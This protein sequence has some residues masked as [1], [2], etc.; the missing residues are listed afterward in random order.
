MPEPLLPIELVSF[1]AVKE[2]A[3]NRINW[4]TASEINNQ[5]QIIERSANGLDGWTEINR[6]E[7]HAFSLELNEYTFLDRFP[8]TESFYRLKAVDFDGFTEYSETIVVKREDNVIEFALSASP[9]P[10]SNSTDL[11]IHSGHDEEAVV[12]ITDVTG[13]VVMTK[14]ISVV[15][16]VN[17]LEVDGS[18]LNSG[19][20][21]VQINSKLNQSTLKLIKN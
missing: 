5:Y 1:T 19:I 17:V 14:N 20:Y 10:F 11:Y 15:I 8:L 4:V 21:F 16:G 18:D 7:G 2:G 13:K 3:F 6:Q 9:N 12:T